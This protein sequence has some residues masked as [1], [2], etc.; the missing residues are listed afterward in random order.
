MN[1]YG[2]GSERKALE[3]YIRNHNLSDNINLHGN[4]EKEVV[5]QAYKNSHFLILMS[6]SE[7]WPKVVAEAMFWKCLPISTEV[8]C[9][10]EILDMGSRG[11][12]VQDN[13][14]A[15]VKEIE[16]YIKDK[17]LYTSKIENA[18]NWSRQ[19]TL[20]RFDNE[21]KDLLKK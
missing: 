2:D 7:G 5:K 20:N 8:S 3:E 21:I 11:S 10:P 16:N 1:I 4:A 18:F 19:Y 12:L 13:V 17:A 9:V 15:I 6:K 14:Q